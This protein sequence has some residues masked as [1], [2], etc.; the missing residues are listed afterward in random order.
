MPKRRTAMEKLKALHDSLQFETDIAACKALGVNRATLYR[1]RKRCG[2]PSEIHLIT[3]LTDCR[4]VRKSHSQQIPPE[5]ESM[6]RDIRK[7][8]GWGSTR[9]KRICNVIGFKVSRR[10]VDRV[11]QQARKAPM[12]SGDVA[13]DPPPQEVDAKQMAIRFDPQKFEE[14]LQQIAEIAPKRLMRQLQDYNRSQ[15]K[16]LHAFEEFEQRLGEHNSEDFR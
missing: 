5:A 13:D 15:K 4:P 9:I 12:T 14:T 16:I 10:T 8:L 7:E 1:W 2:S 6:I 11:L 3:S